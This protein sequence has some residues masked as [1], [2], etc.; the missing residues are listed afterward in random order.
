MKQKHMKQ[1]KPCF[2]AKKHFYKDRESDCKRCGFKRK[3][4]LKIKGIV[5]E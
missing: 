1:L 3:C 5:D 4:L 2:G